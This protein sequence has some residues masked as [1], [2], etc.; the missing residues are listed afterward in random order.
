MP[1]LV[2]RVLIRGADEFFKCL[3]KVVEFLL[4]LESHW[5]MIELLVITEFHLTK[6]VIRSKVFGD[7]LQPR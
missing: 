6:R 7:I 4:A 2:V 5:H 3:L 1:R